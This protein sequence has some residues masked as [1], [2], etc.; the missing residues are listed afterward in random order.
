MNFMVD[1]GLLTVVNKQKQITPPILDVA[2]EQYLVRR[3]K[4]N[5]LKQ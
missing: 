3:M 1:A 5:Y 2:L 4:S